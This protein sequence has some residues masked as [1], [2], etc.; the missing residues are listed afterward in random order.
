MALIEAQ[1]LKKT[2]KI[3]T[4]DVPALKGVSFKIEYGEFVAIMG[5]SG[6]GK[7]TLMNLIG[8][9]DRPTGGKYIL[10][11]FDASK[12]SDA[13]RAEVRNRK[14]GF[15]FQSFNL[16]PKMSAFKNAMLPMMYSTGPKDAKKVR[17]ALKSVG[18]EHRMHHTPMQLSGGEQQRVA[19]ARSLVNDPPVVLGDEPTGNLDSTT[20]VEIMAIF[21]HLNNEGKTVI[22]VT[23]E[24]DIAQHAKR[25]LRFRDG[26]LESDEAVEE[27][28]IAVPKPKD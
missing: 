8:C 23:H 24:P 15:V 14:I 18:L 16:L 19:V 6:S 26:L 25:I 13:A 3:G 9:L 5:P 28:L 7:S 22:I 21:Q 20:G 10:D 2:Y 12:L 11:G 1:D 4:I 17:E 27:Q